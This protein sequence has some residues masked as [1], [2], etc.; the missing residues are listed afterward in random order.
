MVNKISF[1]ICQNY[2]FDF[3]ICVAVSSEINLKGKLLVSFDP[4]SAACR[5]VTAKFLGRALAPAGSIVPTSHSGPQAAAT[6][7]GPYTEA[8][9][10]CLAWPAQVSLTVFSSAHPSFQGP[11]LC[12]FFIRYNLSSK[13]T[14]SRI[15]HF[16]FFWYVLVR[17]SSFNLFMAKVLPCST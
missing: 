9:V 13:R 7:S 8:R 1:L 4:L 14:E 2:G 11:H 6:L 17:R 12:H 16:C 10:T 3:K 15:V 5:G